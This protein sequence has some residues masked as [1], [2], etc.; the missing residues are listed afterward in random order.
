MVWGMAR[1]EYPN[2]VVKNRMGNEI[3]AFIYHR[4]DGE[5]FEEQLRYLKANGYQ[6]VDTEQIKQAL[7]SGVGL[8]EKPVFLTFD[9]GLEN[10][11]TVAYPLLRSYG[12]RGILFVAPFW[13]GKEGMAS[14]QQIM[15]MH[16]SGWVDVESHSFSHGMI[17]VSPK[18]VDFFHP[19]Y[20]YYQRWSFPFSEENSFETSPPLPAWGTPVYRSVSCLS[21]DEKYLSDPLLEKKCTSYVKERGGKNFFNDPLW[22]FRLRRVVKKYFQLNPLVETYETKEEQAARIRREL[23]LS[24]RTIEEK[25]PG[26]KVESFSYPY[27]E[28]GKVTD[29]VLRECGYRVVFGGIAKDSGFGR[30]GG[31]FAFFRRVSGDFVMRLPGENRQSLLKLFLLK[32]SRRLR[33]RQM[34]Y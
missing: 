30:S 22:R 6:A 13:I 12:F 24:K 15:E 19:G 10:F 7:F 29:Q 27:H 32:G 25:L 9:D 16:E 20:V 26:K 1:G 34:L 8:P 17:P 2:F 18:I 28:H 31:R 11:Y 23:E 33:N 5:V 21:E 14:W 3:P 4:V